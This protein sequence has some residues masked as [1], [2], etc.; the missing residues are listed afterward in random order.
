MENLG[1][2]LSQLHVIEDQRDVELD[3]K[4]EIQ[5]TLQNYNKARQ[6]YFRPDSSWITRSRPFKRDEVERESSTTA[7]WK[8]EA[9]KKMRVSPEPEPEAGRKMRASPEPEPA[10]GG[11]MRVSPL[12]PDQEY[13]MIV[14]RL[15]T[16]GA[17]NLFQDEKFP[18]QNSLLPQ[19]SLSLEEIKWMRP[20][21]SDNE[22]PSCI[23]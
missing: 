21:V 20:R 10:A 16:G 23:F 18:C 2:S 3:D 22:S 17:G 5:E 12:Y 13:D 14:R 15:G 1:E 9:E 6:S 11:K 8:P 4:M 7:G 19:N